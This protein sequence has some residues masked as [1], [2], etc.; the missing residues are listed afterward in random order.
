MDWKELGWLWVL[1]FLVMQEFLFLLASFRS[2]NGKAEG[3][4]AISPQGRHGVTALKARKRR[5]LSDVGRIYGVCG[6]ETR[7]DKAKQGSAFKLLEPTPVGAWTSNTVVQTEQTSR[8]GIFFLNYFI[9]VT[10]RD[11]QVWTALRVFGV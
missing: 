4:E 11:A 7:E 6:E 1:F 5:L 9:F 2:P 10:R 8:F 3:A